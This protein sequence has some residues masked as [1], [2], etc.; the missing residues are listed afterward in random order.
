MTETKMFKALNID[1]LIFFTG[2]DA[3]IEQAEKVET[4]AASAINEI[5]SNP[6]VLQWEQEAIDAFYIY[7]YPDNS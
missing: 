7:G 3:E 4:A 6:I 5:V 1:P 2:S